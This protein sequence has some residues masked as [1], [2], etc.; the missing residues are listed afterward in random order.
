MQK[1]H[2]HIFVLF[3]EI[4]K[5]CYNIQ[6]IK[7]MTSSAALHNV[8]E[9]FVAETVKNLNSVINMLKEACQEFYAKEI[10]R[11]TSRKM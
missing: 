7:Q 2:T 3:K 6:K 10:Q 9:N 1:I 4:D 8:L 5:L 11:T